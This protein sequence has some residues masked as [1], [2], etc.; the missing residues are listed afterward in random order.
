[1][2]QFAPVPAN[3]QAQNVPSNNAFLFSLSPFNPIDG[4]KKLEVLPEKRYQ[5]IRRHKFAGP[6]WGKD[7]EELCFNNQ[8]VTTEIDA[9]G[10]YDVSGI[11]NPTTYFAGESSFQADD[12]EVFTVGGKNI[13]Y[14]NQKKYD[15]AFF[16]ECTLMYNGVLYYLY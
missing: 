12:I 11:S 16:T 5:A 15:C 10:V 9:G 4:S 7:K 13:N 3:N 1:M 8:Q 14:S 6:C 2:L